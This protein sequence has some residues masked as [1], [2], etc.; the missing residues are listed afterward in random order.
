V[1]QKEDEKYHLFTSRGHE[2][3]NKKKST[4]WQAECLCREHYTLM[5]LPSKSSSVVDARHPVSMLFCSDTKAAL[6]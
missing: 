6:H 2:V 5:L 1:Q 4:C 3:F